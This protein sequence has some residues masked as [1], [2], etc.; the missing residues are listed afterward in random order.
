MRVVAIGAGIPA[1]LDKGATA[2]ASPD[3]PPEFAV[4][5]EALKR[6]ELSA[7]EREEIYWAMH[8]YF[9]EKLGC[10]SVTFL[11]RE[12]AK[13]SLVCATT[14]HEVTCRASPSMA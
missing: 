4:W 10:G 2:V 12:I 8:D 9:A 7:E 3:D 6:R 14:Q 13:S 5:L 1:A 11:G